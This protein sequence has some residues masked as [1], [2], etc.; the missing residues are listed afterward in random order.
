MKGG[1]RKIV[2][3]NEEKVHFSPNFH[4]FSHTFWAL[5]LHIPAP[6]VT[7]VAAS[8]DFLWFRKCWKWES[9]FAAAPFLGRCMAFSMLW[10]WYPGV[11]SCPWLFIFFAEGGSGSSWREPSLKWKVSILFLK[12]TSESPAMAIILHCEKNMHYE[13]KTLQIL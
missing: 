5:K 7:I 13:G 6:L 11:Y 1:K 12:E 8:S 9:P 4:Y 3:A 10:R 2:R